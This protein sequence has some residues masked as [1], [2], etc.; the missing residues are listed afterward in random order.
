MSG[1]KSY[2][3]K[4]GTNLLGINNPLNVGG[5][6]DTSKNTI[7]NNTF[8][9]NIKEL[10][11]RQVRDVSIENQQKALKE[12]KILQTEKEIL[13]DPNFNEYHTHSDRINEQQLKNQKLEEARKEMINYAKDYVGNPY[14]WGGTSLTDGVDCSG[15][16]QA[17]YKK[18]GVD[19]PHNS[20]AQREAG[21]TIEGLGNA[22]PGDLI[23][24]KGHVA[25]YA[26]DGTMIH[27]KNSRSGIVHEQI[28]AYWANRIV[29]IV[30]PDAMV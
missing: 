9:D 12:A 13:S 26:G 30:R 11:N 19:L 28:G 27:A 22:K 2:I 5:N 4:K 16:T 3:V 24:F 15:F 25:L 1:L 23:C 14:V 10:R 7:I 8:E 20:L 17:I 21:I 18:Y 6:F 29:K